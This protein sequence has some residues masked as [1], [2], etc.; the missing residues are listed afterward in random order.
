MPVAHSIPLNETFVRRPKGVYFISDLQID[1]IYGQDTQLE[2]A[3]LVD[4][5]LTPVTEEHYLGSNQS[6]PE[7]EVIFSGWGM[8]VMDETFFSRFPRLKIVFYGAG[9]VKPHVTDAFWRRGIRIT[10][11]AA[12]NAIPVAEYTCAQIIQALKKGWQTALYIRK[13]RKFPDYAIP[14][15]AYQTT[16]GLLSLGLIGRMVA[17]R[18]RHYDVKIIAYDPLVTQEEARRLQVTLVSLEEIFSLSDVVSCHTPWL[19]ETYRMI[20]GHHFASLKP[21]AS[22]INTARGAIV[23]EE[24]MI[25]VLQERLDIMAILDVTD[26]EPPAQGS[27]LY[28]LENVILTPHIAGSMGNECRRMGQYMVKELQRYLS[29]EPLLYEVKEDQAL[30]MA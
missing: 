25:E 20:R 22:F 2:I 15:G 4:I 26:P 5:P 16:V 10:N 28:K 7:V 17:K 19:P 8:T 23:F 30:V 11:A 13:E 27:L 1:K 29:G 12:A 3:Q 21:Q 6:W 14:P 18:L 24:E 9:S